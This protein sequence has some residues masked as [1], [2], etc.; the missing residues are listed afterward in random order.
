[1]LLLAVIV[2]ALDRRCH[3]F[4]V[5][6]DLR[7]EDGK[8]VFAFFY[9]HRELKR[10]WRVKAGYVPLMPNVLGYLAVRL[11]PRTAPYFMTLLPVTFAVAA[12]SVFFAAVAASCSGRD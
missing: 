4:F 9:Q 7:A 10:L 6:P 12:F 11:P 3:A 2:V 5:N 1:M 8:S